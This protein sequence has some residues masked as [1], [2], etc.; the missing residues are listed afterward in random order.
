MKCSLAS[1]S[2]KPKLLRNFFFK[3]RLMILVS[4]PSTLVVSLHSIPWKTALPYSL[5]FASALEFL[6]IWNG[7]S[8]ADPGEIHKHWLLSLARWTTNRNALK[9]MRK[10]GL[11]KNNKNKNFRN[12]CFC[13]SVSGY[14]EKSKQTKYLI[15][16]C[17]KTAWL[18]NRIK[19]HESR[20]QACMCKIMHR[21]PV[22]YK[23]THL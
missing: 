6:A 14:F 10:F 23:Q 16:L 3:L 2:C 11:E 12:T 1:R 4:V 21:Y 8:Y 22:E 18:P 20:E 13:F 17:K 9:Q 5:N 19:Q 7:L 15:W